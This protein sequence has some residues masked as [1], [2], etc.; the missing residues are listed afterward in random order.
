MT[1]EATQTSAVESTSTS[2]SAASVETTHSTEDIQDVTSTTTGVTSE[3]PTT[4][5]TTVQTGTDSTAAATTAETTATTDLSSSTDTTSDITPATDGSTSTSTSTTD[6]TSTEGS[7]PEAEAEISGPPVGSGP[8][9]NQQN[10]VSLI[11][12]LYTEKPGVPSPP[13]NFIGSLA[14]TGSSPGVASDVPVDVNASQSQGNNNVTVTFGLPGGIDALAAQ[15]TSTLVNKPIPGSQPVSNDNP[16][17]SGW[18]QIQNISNPIINSSAVLSN[19]SS[20]SESITSQINNVSS[21]IGIPNPLQDQQAENKPPPGVSQ[22]T[23]FLGTFQELGSQITDPLINSSGSSAIDGVV[24]Q[25]QN[26]GSQISGGVSSATNAFVGAGTDSS[27]AVGQIPNQLQQIITNN[28]LN[29]FQDQPSDKVP[30]DVQSLATLPQA[31]I[32]KPIQSPPAGVSQDTSF[33]GTIQGIGSQITNPFGISNSNNSSVSSGIDAIASQFQNIG[34]Q[35]AGGISN[36]TNTLTGSGSSTTVT[37]ET[38]TEAPSNS[39]A[40]STDNSVSQDTGI[41]G[42]LQEIGT[43]ITQ[44]GSSNS[45]NSSG[46][47]TLAGIG[48]QF[49][50]VGSQIA[51][52]ISNATS[53]VTE[54]QIP[55]LVNNGNVNLTSPWGSITTGNA[56]KNNSAVTEVLD[57]LNAISQAVSQKPVT[58]QL[59][60]IMNQLQ[61]NKPTL[62]NDVSIGDLPGQLQT[63]GSNILN[64]A[65]DWNVVNKVP[66][67]GNWIGSNNDK[68]PK[69]ITARPTLR[70]PSCHQI[71]GTVN[72]VP[73]RRTRIMGGNAVNPPN[74]YPWNVR[75]IYFKS[76]AG[77]GSLINDRAIITTA[78][79]V[80]S[81]P[82][83]S[84]AAVLFKVYDRMSTSEE[85]LMKKVAKVIPH[86][87]YDPS[88]IFD[89][90]IGIVIT[91]SPVP[92]SRTLVP[93]CLPTYFESY[94]GTEATVAGWGSDMAGGLQSPI[95]LEV[96]IPLYT[97]AECSMTRPNVTSNNLCGGTLKPIP[98]SSIKSTC[99]VS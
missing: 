81:M 52:G 29:P 95:P 86:P 23:S 72:S 39:N 42:S 96:T 27:A 35:I 24:S 36:V 51:A 45:N 40:S 69:N 46:S 71:C 98:P 4:T 66:V 59:Q 85:S 74:K 1:T 82:L 61:P 43:Q 25:F 49:Q 19:I 55:Q 5:S 92:L 91:D 8:S 34:S 93:I 79:I 15:L 38:T 13:Q 41:F 83:Y 6:Q 67:I 97:N 31:N 3:V 7:A 94:G 21:A 30:I 26:V 44:L 48:S 75:F 78:T 33:I 60:G 58:N 89:N 87:Q 14:L 64:G 16:F 11:S 22:D 63:I 57:Q 99:E 17:F 50:N 2:E 47:P 88:N 10:V 37:S 90:N 65:L 80:N 68:K 56:R 73:V 84:Q 20:I 76:D 18:G 9:S 62:S 12:N 28:P 53:A 54:V 32:S 70:C 77:Q